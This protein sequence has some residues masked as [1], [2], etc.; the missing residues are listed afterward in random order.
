MQ[1]GW[2][3]SGRVWYS[4]VELGRTI[5]NA[6]SEGTRITSQ[7]LRSFS[8]RARRAQS[9][10]LSLPPSS[11]HNYSPT[12]DPAIDTLRLEYLLGPC[13]LLALIF[14]YRLSVPSLPSP[15][16]P[17][18]TPPP[19][20]TP[21]RSSPM[22]I[23]WSFSIYLEAVGILPQLFMLQRTGE[24]ETITTHYLFALGAY[25]AL[26]VPNWVYRYF[27]EDTVRCLFF[28]V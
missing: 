18:L 14:N 19:T 17:T 13:A 25:R 1:E 15:L 3:R 20:R 22:E 9:L 6:R 21:Q 7:H 26:Y 4:S 27:T 24:A 16:P 8:R 2:E 11:F 23:L 28:W 10:I 12:Q 5:G